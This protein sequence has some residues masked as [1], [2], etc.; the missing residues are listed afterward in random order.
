[1]ADAKFDLK[2]IPEFDGSTSVVDWIERVELTC[3]LC[4]VKQV[5]LVIPLRLAGGALDVYQQ[6]S[7]NEKSNVEQTKAALYKAFA[8]DPCTAYERFATRKLLAGETVDVFFAGL[9]KLAV[10]FGGLPEQTFVYAF[11]AGLP[12][13]VKQ[14]LRASTSIE[15]TPIE[16]LL[17]RARAIIKD[18]AE[19]EEH[20]V[21]AA[22]PSQ[23]VLKNPQRSDQH[24]KVNCFRCGRSGHIAKNCMDRSRGR[25]R[26]FQCGGIGHMASSCPGNESGDKMSAPLC[27]PDKM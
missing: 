13:R 24:A 15:A 14:L 22:Q 26:C 3:R 12:V 6:L 8:M 7:E 25:I 27:S 20:V 21:M 18:E 17:E 9:K 5:E 1:M 10:L 16:Q 23:S 11:V 19:L 2:L 4:G